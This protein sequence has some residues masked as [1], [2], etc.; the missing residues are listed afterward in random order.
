MPDIFKALA[1]IMAWV[2]WIVALVIGF[3]AFA[4]GMISGALYSTTQPTPMIFPALWAVAGFYA[5]AAVV[6]MILRKKME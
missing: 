6:I 2:L 4:V 3:S 1:T 5:L